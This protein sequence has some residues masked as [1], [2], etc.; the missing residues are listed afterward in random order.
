M[1]KEASY[2]HLTLSAHY[3]REIY[4][5][6]GLGIVRGEFSGLACQVS[7][8]AVAAAVETG[9]RDPSPLLLF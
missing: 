4:N 6:V 2:D 3:R 9:Q 7:A 1:L 5:L 8:R